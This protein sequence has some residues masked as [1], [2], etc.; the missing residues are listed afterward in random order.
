MNCKLEVPIYRQA[1]RQKYEKDTAS[2]ENKVG[3][4]F[5]FKQSTAKTDFTIETKEV[6][7]GDCIGLSLECNNIA[8][9]HK[10]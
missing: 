6:A 10:V 9:N 4:Y 2:V 5:G 1:N 7:P 3:G 8:C